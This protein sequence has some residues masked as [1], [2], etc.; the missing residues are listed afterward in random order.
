MLQMHELLTY[1]NQQ[2]VVT[3]LILAQAGMVGHD[4]VPDR[5]DLSQRHRS[6]CCASSRPVGR[7]GGPLSVIKKRTGS[8]ENTIREFRIDSHG[9]RVGERLIEFR[10]V[11]TGV[12]TYEGQNARSDEGTPKRWMND[13]APVLILAPSGRD[14]A[15]AAAILGEVGIVR[16]RVPG[17]G[18]ACV[19]S[20]PGG[21]GDCDG[22]SSAAL[23]PES[24]CNLGPPTATLVG[25]SL[26]AAHFPGQPC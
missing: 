21:R 12:P 9:V 6:C 10:G 13:T 4:G 24:A 11:L 14:G 15:V 20:G 3:I 23:R 26:C 17:P 25:L 1:L 16:D 22:R 18:R 19:R 2:G 8:H 5:S 7:S